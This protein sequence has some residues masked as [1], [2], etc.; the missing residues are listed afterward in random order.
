VDI[1][2]PEPGLF[3]LVAVGAGEALKIAAP[4]DNLRVLLTASR[5]V[6]IGLPDGRT[7]AFG[8]DELRSYAEPVTVSPSGDEDRL[9]T[10]VY[11][12][13]AH[14]YDAA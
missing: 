9:D 10:V 5:P 12:R 6:T 8:K 2:I 4:A 1:L 7:E 3:R 13:T 14:R 11:V